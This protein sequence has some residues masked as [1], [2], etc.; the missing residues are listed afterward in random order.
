MSTQSISSAADG[1]S[2]R[3]LNMAR[4]LV[5]FVLAAAAL[6]APLVLS[7]IYQLNVLVFAAINAIMASGLAIVVRTGRLSLAQATF[8]GVG[9]YLTGILVTQHNWNYWLALPCAAICA[10]AFGLILGLASLR[11]RGFYFAVATLTFGQLAY[12]VLGAWSSVTGGFSG[13]FGLPHPPRLGFVNFNDPRHYYY[14]MLA[15]LGLTLIIRLLCTSWTRFGRALSLLGEDD[16]LAQA[17]GVPST[18]YRLSAFAI[19]SAIGGVGGS[20]NAHFIQGISPP[21]IAPAVSVFVVVM[22][23]AGGVRSLLGPVI[24][25]VILTAIPELLRASAEWSMVVFGVFL[26]G[27]VFLFRDG[28]V[29]LVSRFAT[30]LLGE[31]EAGAEAHCGVGALGA[32]GPAPPRNSPPLRGDALTC[33]EVSCAFGS[34]VVLKRVDLVV[35]PGVIHGLIG[36]NGAGKTTLFNVVTGMAPL[37]KGEV[38]VGGASVTPRPSAMS[39][40][41]LSRTFQ[42]ARVFMERTA[43]DNVSLAAE[44]SGH[45]IDPDYLSWVVAVCGLKPIESRVASKLSHFERRLVTIAMAIAARPSLVLLDEPLAGLDDTET[46]E[47]Q[48]LIRR[49]HAELGCAILLIEHKLGVVMKICQWLSVLDNGAIIAE[50]APAEVA[51]NPAVI[52]AYLGA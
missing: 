11:L 14:F 22:V 45:A 15:A 39:R 4:R 21:D 7:N 50:G 5:Y 24:G 34:N 6:G 42:H 9:G 28:L 52:E 38:R 18:P 40:L 29:S 2:A 46:Q 30:K 37:S 47:V 36:P 25:A 12:V 33:A 19:S 44:M 49:L 51:K 26:I 17:I 8:G 35:K 32:A 31:P 20:F 41:G 16:V 23:M 27:Y 3:R 13:M 10:A 48:A 43:K 1:G